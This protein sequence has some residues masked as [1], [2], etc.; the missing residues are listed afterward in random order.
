V[1]RGGQPIQEIEL[2]SRLQ[3]DINAEDIPGL[4]PRFYVIEA[5]NHANY[6]FHG[7]WNRLAPEEKEEIVAH[8]IMMNIIENN[9]NDIVAQEIERKKKKNKPR[10]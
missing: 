9:K 7:N 8:Y 3:V 4:I 2:K 10:G 5:C 1:T 6:R